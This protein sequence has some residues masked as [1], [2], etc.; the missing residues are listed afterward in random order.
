MKKYIELV[1]TVRVFRQIDIIT[2]SFTKNDD[3]II[4]DADEL[5]G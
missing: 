3:D 5:W 2:T 1:I 4:I